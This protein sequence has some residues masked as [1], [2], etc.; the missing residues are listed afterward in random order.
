MTL[1][2]RFQE[3]DLG[4][5]K[6]LGWLKKQLE[7]Q[8]HGLT[9][10]LEEIWPS[11]AS[12]SAWLGGD[13]EDWER[14]PYYCDGLVPLAYILGEDWLIKKAEKWMNSVL[15]GQDP[16][17][18]FGPRTNPDWWPRMVMLKALISYHEA[19]KDPR[20][21][22]FMSNYFKYQSSALQAKPLE[23]WAWAR[24]FENL[25]SIFW[26]YNR[27]K[28]PFLID[29]AKLILNQTINWSEIFNDFPYVERTEKYLPKDL[30]AKVKSYSGWPKVLSHPEEFGLAKQEVERLFFIYHTTHV[31][32]VAMALKEPAMK[33]QIKHDERYREVALKAI[34]NLMK[35]HGQP[36]GMFSGD[37]HLNGRKTTQ[38]TELCAVVEF[39]FSLENLFRV[40]GEPRFADY[41]EKVAY[42]ALPATIRPEFYAHQYDQQVNQVLCTV[43]KRNWY[44]NN[45]D[46]NIFGLEPNFGCCTANMHQGWPKLVKNLFMLD[47]SDCFVAV[48]YAPCVLNYN[49]P[50]GHSCQIFEETDYPF[51]D[52]ITL[53]IS[54][55][56]DIRVA[57]RIPS[58]SKSTLIVLNGERKEVL[59]QPLVVLQIPKGK[60]KVRLKFDFEIEPVSWSD[61]T[62]YLQRGPLIF[63]LKIKEEWKKIQGKEPFADYEVY[64]RSDW[65]YALILSK[66][67]KLIKTTIPENS[68]PFYSKDTPIKIRLKAFKV[69]EWTLVNGSAAEPPKVDE[70]HIKENGINEVELVPYGCT[71]LRITEFPYVK[72][73]G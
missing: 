49:W 63:S 65:N 73:G 64:P 13:G 15:S 11:V 72:L 24:G 35:Y 26:L 29:L 44:N 2:S 23:H 9:G 6:P 28:E 46:S 61:H 50:D 54:S 67:I 39:M 8:M 12:N 25:I 7:L 56:K 20:V 52:E 19:T 68:V 14:G 31:V 60:S 21:I 41:L 45:D 10:H 38:G 43:Q 62:V 1:K 3:L 48:V 59:N 57:V 30:M 34:E 37:E 71:A 69:P 55:S 4:V 27:V 5:I 16:E 32:N 58:W 17:G 53:S 47:Q 40:F 42:N 70:S 22:K 66:D 51:D 36:N 33:Y 18:F